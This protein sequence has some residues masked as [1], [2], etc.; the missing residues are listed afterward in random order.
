[1]EKKLHNVCARR[2]VYQFVFISVSSKSAHYI[3]MSNFNNRPTMRT[4]GP[5]PLSRWTTAVLFVSFSLYAAQGSEHPSQHLDSMGS[6]HLKN[7]LQ[8]QNLCRYRR[9][10]QRYSF[11]QLLEPES[12]EENCVL[13]TGSGSGAALPSGW[14]EDTPP[15][16][17][18]VCV[19]LILC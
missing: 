4:C 3:S 5:S 17:V 13:H 15:S 18:S 6:Y 11:L 1:M 14:T 8:C 2:S 12:E 9:L 7:R 10:C 19:T 16:L